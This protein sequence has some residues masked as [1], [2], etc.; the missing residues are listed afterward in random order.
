M[1]R[2]GLEGARRASRSHLCGAKAHFLF[3]GSSSC[4]GSLSRRSLGP[5]ALPSVLSSSPSYWIC[6]HSSSNNTLWLGGGS[7]ER[8]Y[9]TN[10]SPTRKP[11]R[12]DDDED[13]DVVVNEAEDL[14]A[15]LEQLPPEFVAMLKKESEVPR[16]PKHVDKAY[17]KRLQE[18]EEESK[19]GIKWRLV[20]AAVV[21]RPPVCKPQPPHWEQEYW[22]WLTEKSI[23]QAHT[24]EERLELMEQ[25]QAKKAGAKKKDKKK[26][27]SGDEQEEEGMLDLPNIYRGLLKQKELREVGRTWSRETEDDRRNNRKSLNRKLDRT[28]YLLVKKAREEHAWQFPQGGIEEGETMQKCAER[29]LREECGAELEIFTHD[30][31]PSHC[32]SYPLP[33]KEQKKFGATGSK[34]FFYEMLHIEGAPKLNQ[35]ELE[36]YVW[37]TKEEMADY[38]SPSLYESIKDV[39]RE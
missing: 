29:E 12:Y 34:V 17:R 6:G 7:S 19:Q 30:S 5:S 24:L 38:L 32:Y 18:M 14:K 4:R 13:E 23:K 20:G 35:A 22:D 27:Q 26:K 21:Q 3:A 1:R 25:D 15:V 36:D 37:V 11:P 28:L 31:I 9:A 10:P 2:T 33:E 16:V 8:G 39:L